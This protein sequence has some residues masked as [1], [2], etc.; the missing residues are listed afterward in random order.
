MSDNDRVENQALAE[1]LR[2]VRTMNDKIDKQDKEIN[3][4]K[5]RLERGASSIESAEKN[6]DDLREVRDEQ[7]VLKTKFAII[8]SGLAIAATAGITGAVL[9]A[10]ALLKH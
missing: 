9:G 2:L 10:I 8:W 4:I 7:I 5:L 1:V 3:D 6:G